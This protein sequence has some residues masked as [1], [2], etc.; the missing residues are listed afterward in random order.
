MANAL[1]CM[2]DS[3]HKAM[4]F[5]VDLSLRWLFHSAGSAGSSLRTWQCWCESWVKTRLNADAQEQKCAMCFI[6]FLWHEFRKW[7]HYTSFVFISLFHLS[8]Y[9]TFLMQSFLCSFIFFYF[10][11]CP[12]VHW[13]QNIGSLYV[14][15]SCHSLVGFFFD[16]LMAIGYWG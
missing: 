5:S 8:F 4:P 11:P 9:W 15:S 10:A 14:S 6:P 3:Q 13:Q 12:Q 2:Y 1:S 7:R 16:F